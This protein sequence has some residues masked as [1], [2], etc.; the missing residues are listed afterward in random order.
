MRELLTLTRRMPWSR[1]QEGRKSFTKAAMAGV[2]GVGMFAALGV[3]AATAAPAAGSCSSPTVTSKSFGTA[4]DLYAGKNL[5]VFQYTLKN[6][7]NVTAEI[8]NYGGIT[9]SVTVPD[10]QGNPADVMLGFKTLNEYIAE[11]SPPPPAAGGPYF[12]EIIGR[13][14]NRIANASFKIGGNTYTIPVNNGP[15]SLHGG[16]VGFGNHVWASKPVHT[17]GMAGVQ[18]TLVSPDGDG[19]EN[20]GC[21]IGTQPC[22]GYPGTLTLVVTYLL[23]NSGDLFMHYHA[24]VAG[25]PTVVNFTNHAYFNLAGESS[26]TIY[27][28][29][30]MINAS[31][32]TP[33]DANL[34]PT[35]VLAP[36]A[37]TPFDFRTF[38]TIGERIN[39]NDPQLIQAHGYDHNWVLNKTGPAM[40]T[41]FGKLLLAADAKDPGSGRELKVWTD[42]PG[43]QFYTGNFLNGSI[44]GISGHVYR[45][46][47]GYTFET[48]HFPNSPN[49]P[50]FPSTLLKP[51]QQF[52]STTIYQ[53]LP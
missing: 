19:G 16:F 40:S 48:Q 33:T 8:L 12:G 23:D 38:H 27:G 37:G 24:T 49:Q 29:Q 50:N 52:N 11:A 4:F 45:Q 26:G 2:L 47:D 28:E 10:K 35:G 53:F 7:S 30:V 3:G 18:L 13:Y 44:V 5:P 21:V 1:R 46:S 9:Q 39:A 17:S 42:E 6:C 25:K 31:K 20:V 41:P 51:G 34:I 32:Y 36:V 14:A 15:N 43:V 22:T